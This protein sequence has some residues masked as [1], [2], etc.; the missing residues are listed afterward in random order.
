M[1][2]KKLKFE[3]EGQV[4][5]LEIEHY[6]D[7]GWSQAICMNQTVAVS[8]YERWT[9]LDGSDEVEE[10]LETHLAEVED[11]LLNRAKKNFR[12]WKW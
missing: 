4:Y 5:E 10:L 6:L 11:Y 7:K 8:Q 1:E 9:I 2:N 12:D 3:Y